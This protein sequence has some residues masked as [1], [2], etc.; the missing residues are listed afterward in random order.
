MFLWV[1]LHA[2]QSFISQVFGVN[3]MGQIDIEM[4]IY[5]TLLFFKKMISVVVVLI[6]VT[7]AFDKIFHRVKNR[8]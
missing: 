5:K 1:G 2:D 7:L 6:R 8:Q 3:S 4:V